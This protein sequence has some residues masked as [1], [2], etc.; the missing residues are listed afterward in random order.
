MVY[1]VITNAMNSINIFFGNLLFYNLFIYLFYF[2]FFLQLTPRVTPDMLSYTSL[3]L[4]RNS[5]KFKRKIPG[6]AFRWPNFIYYCYLS[7]NLQNLMSRVKWGTELL[8]ELA[9]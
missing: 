1:L 3:F 4:M 2:F 5:R 9:P 6:Q 7:L 8:S